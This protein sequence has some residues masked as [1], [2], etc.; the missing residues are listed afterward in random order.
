MVGQRVKKFEMDMVRRGVLANKFA[1]WLA[2]R[3]PPP[4]SETTHDEV[5]LLGRRKLLP[6]VVEYSKLS[7]L[8][9]NV[10]YK[11]EQWRLALGR[12]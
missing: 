6:V 2:V 10:G 9:C 11:L 1:R 7:Q 5:L 3:G 8:V 12:K 4:S